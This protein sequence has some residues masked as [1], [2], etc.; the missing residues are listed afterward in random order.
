M[1]VVEQEESE[2]GCQK[3]WKGQQR[4]SEVTTEHRP[5]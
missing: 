4:R 1:Q 2:D 5:R 3:L